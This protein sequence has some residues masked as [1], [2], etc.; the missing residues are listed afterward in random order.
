MGTG[1][2]RAPSKAL[3]VALLSLTVA[4]VG[5]TDDSDGQP[6][7]EGPTGAVAGGAG[8]SQGGVFA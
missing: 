4:L 2:R 1:S 5:C 6:A 8:A 3:L 7:A